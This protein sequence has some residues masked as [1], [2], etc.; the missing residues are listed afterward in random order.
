MAGMIGFDNV[1][2]PKGRLEHLSSFSN[3]LNFRQNG[4]YLF[5]A[6]SIT[7]GSSPVTSSSLW[8]IENKE[9]YGDSDYL[10]QSLYSVGQSVCYIR[11]VTDTS[12]GSWQRI[13]NFG[14]NTLG[15]LA[16]A[17]KPHLGL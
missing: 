12:F 2:I 13:D 17:L 1:A 3:S 4:I 11:F 14:C 10:V 5:N 7:D 8:V 15:E 16:A 6:N 9:L